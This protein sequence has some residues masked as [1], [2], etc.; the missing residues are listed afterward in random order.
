[1]I[2]GFAGNDDIQH[3]RSSEG[4]LGWGVGGRARHA[5]YDFPVS[6]V[7]PGCPPQEHLSV[8]FSGPLHSPH[9]G[10][11]IADVGGP[12]G[13]NRASTLCVCKSELFKRGRGCTPDRAQE[14]LTFVRFVPR[15]RLEEVL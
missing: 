10:S 15:V 11:D 14:W 6:L 5:P 13:P 4:L 1:M 2:R 7:L 9:I 12:S 8:K 3:D